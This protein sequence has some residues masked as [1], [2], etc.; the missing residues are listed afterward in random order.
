[1]QA[2][3]RDTVCF[4]NLDQGSKLIIFE[5]IMTTFIVS[6]IFKGHLDSSKNWLGLEIKPP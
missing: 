3:T 1:M 2:I 5:S 6:V 4:T